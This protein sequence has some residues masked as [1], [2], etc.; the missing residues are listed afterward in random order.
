MKL[1]EAAVAAALRKARAADLLLSDPALA[2]ALETY[3]V[4]QVRQ[5]LTPGA[6]PEDVLAARQRCIVAEDVIQGLQQAII[7]ARLITKG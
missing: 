7:D 5:M 1:T 6:S 2:A 3:Q 4:E